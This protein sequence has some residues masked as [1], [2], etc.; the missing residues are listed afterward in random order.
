MKLIKI[1]VPIPGVVASA[2]TFPNFTINFYYYDNLNAIIYVE[3]TFDEARYNEDK[4]CLQAILNDEKL[5]FFPLLIFRN[6]CVLKIEN[7]N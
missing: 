5:N 1:L 2:F 3:D 4:E 6:K 7:L